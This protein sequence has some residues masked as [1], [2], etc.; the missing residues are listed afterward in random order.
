MYRIIGGEI[1]SLKTLSMPKARRLEQD[2][3]NAKPLAE[4]IV[5]AAKMKEIKTAELVAFR[6][7]LTRVETENAACRHLNLSRE[8]ICNTIS[9]TSTSL[10]YL[11][12]LL[13]FGNNE[14][15]LE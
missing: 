4:M 13:H 5:P 15:V 7:N 1:Q 9:T 10:R 6:A 3:K 12:A 8:E 2:F 11:D 14:D